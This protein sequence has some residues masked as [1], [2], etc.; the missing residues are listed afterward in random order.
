MQLRWYDRILVA[1]GG[2]VLV[3]L[4]V[5]VILAAGGVITLPEP[6]AFDSWLGT[7]WQWM[8]LIFLAGALIVAW[9]L[10]LVIRPFRRADKSGRYYVLKD[11]EGGDVRISVSAIENLVN[12]RLGAYEPIL[13]SRIKIGG[14]EDAMQITLRLTLRTDVQI[15]NLID[16]V[17]DDIKQSIQHSAGVDVSGVKVFVEATKDDGASKTEM[18]YIEANSGA[19]ETP[20]AAPAKAEA[21]ADYLNTAA[22]YTTPIVV[23]GDGKAHTAVKPE[24][25]DA[26]ASARP[27]DTAPDAQTDEPLIKTLSEEAFP[28][29]E[30][31]EDGYDI[32]TQETQDSVFDMKEDADG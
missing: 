31:P 9:G 6:L 5:G 25:S 17:R 32:D 23:T 3:A 2:L 4:G 20:Q 24:D 30:E 26:D 16:E 8:P 12:R 19:I 21:E 10:W 14:R 22:F 15:P 11:T 28:F 18:K 27:A 1:L 13:G 29:P 7:G